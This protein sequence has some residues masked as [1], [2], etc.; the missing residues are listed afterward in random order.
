M[1]LHFPCVRG[2]LLVI[3]S[4]IG[5][6]VREILEENSY[7]QVCIAHHVK[8]YGQ[9]RADVGVDRGHQTSIVPVRCTRWPTTLFIR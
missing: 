1:P 2:I 4:S 7:L 9:R 5:L 6:V 8:T 3:P